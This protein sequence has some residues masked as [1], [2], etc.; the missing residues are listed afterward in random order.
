MDIPNDTT[1]IALWLRNKLGTD[2]AWVNRGIHQVIKPE[3]IRTIGNTDSVFPMLPTLCKIKL[4]LGILHLPKPTLKACEQDLRKLLAQAK[5]DDGDEWIRC[6]GNLVE[7]FLSNEKNFK[8]N[9]I[10]NEIAEKTLADLTKAKETAER[11]DDEE[12]T[13]EELSSH[14]HVLAGIQA[15]DECKYLN[16]SLLDYHY[17]NLL[18]NKH[19]A[20][21]LLESSDFVT[22]DTLIEEHRNTLS[23]LSE[24]AKEAQSMIQSGYSGITNRSR[25]IYGDGT[26]M[27]DSSKDSAFLKS[28]HKIRHQTSTGISVPSSFNKNS[29]QQAAAVAAQ[30]AQIQAKSVVSSGPNKTVQVL[31]DL[32]ELKALS[33][34]RK[35]NKKLEKLK[36]ERTKSSENMSSDGTAP[37]SAISDQ[38][39]SFV[40]DPSL[41]VQGSMP[42]SSGMNSM[43]QSMNQSFG[44]S[45]GGDPFQGYQTQNSNQ[46]MGGHS[47]YEQS[48]SFQMQA[49]QDPYGP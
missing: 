7:F 42:G 5:E 16:S 41:A 1:D 23:E 31:D 21:N 11:Y 43:E 39:P 13:I 22:S 34:R 12:E 33:K 28:D 15:P 44:S 8:E 37:N 48:P 29:A 40:H 30:N 10:L 46:P 4:L 49:I 18:V 24:R 27:E 3:L 47:A 14:V 17:S 25:M 20:E 9:S 38:H 19:S 35:T 32:D 26:T 36:T 45:G 6:T 2:E